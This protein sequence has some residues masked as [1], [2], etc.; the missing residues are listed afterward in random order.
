[1]L[2]VLGSSMMLMGVPIAALVSIAAVRTQGQFRWGVTA[3]V[4]SAA[5][6]LALLLMFAGVL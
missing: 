6:A 5:E 4:V 2:Y 1:M 3:L